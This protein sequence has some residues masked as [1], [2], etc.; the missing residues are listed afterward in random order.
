M[1][2]ERQGGRDYKKDWLRG[3]EEQMIV[4]MNHLKDEPDHQPML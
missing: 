1:E 3:D 4:D 2:V